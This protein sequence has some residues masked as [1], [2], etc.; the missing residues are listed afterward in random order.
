MAL[1][2]LT[3]LATAV[4]WAPDIV[5]LVDR[6]VVMGGTG[7]NGPGNV[8][9]S[10]EFN[11][12]VDP[13]AVRVVLRSG[14]PLELVGWDV[15]IASAVVSPDRERELRAIGTL[16]SSFSLDIQAVLSD[17]ANHET[18]LSGP[19]LPDPIAMAHAIDPSPAAV[20]Q[21]AVDIAIGPPPMA[22]ALIVD[23]FGFTGAPVN[24]TMVT[25]YPENHFFS[26]LAERLA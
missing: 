23:R 26:M 10:A 3:N 6:V 17:Y 7:M 21:V 16:F 11:F 22:G 1:G 12:W 18:L 14:L 13:E 2:P 24:V 20:T 4:L 9:P 8:S 15:S 5:E 25:D 19:D